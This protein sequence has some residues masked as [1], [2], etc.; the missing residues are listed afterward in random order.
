MTKFN[1]ISDKDFNS[2]LASAVK[3]RA[4]YGEKMTS[5]LKVCIEHALKTE[6]L[7]KGNLALVTL[8]DK[9]FSVNALKKIKAYLLAYLPFAR[10]QK[11]EKHPLGRMS[12]GERE[13]IGFYFFESEEEI[14][15]Y[16]S[17]LPTYFEF[18]S[19]KK[20]KK[21]PPLLEALDA[22]IKKYSKE[23]AELAL[24]EDVLLSK[25]VSLQAEG[26]QLLTSALGI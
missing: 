15:E 4:Q 14:Q 3:S 21:N 1:I 26:E 13:E 25:L 12:K 18:S 17:E 7:D 24:G 9:G 10:A 23:D 5:L 8:K 2:L 11:S 20:E 22:L 6:T 16:L 19:P